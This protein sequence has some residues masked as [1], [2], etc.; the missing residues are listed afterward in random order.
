M[1]HMS[2]L[3]W[4]QND[5]RDAS[6]LCP[7]KLSSGNC[8]GGSPI[9]H[10]LRMWTWMRN[11]EQMTSHGSVSVSLEDWLAENRYTKVLFRGIFRADYLH[12][13]LAQG[14]VASTNRCDFGFGQYYTDSYEVARRFAVAGG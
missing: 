14:P 1:G 3:N 9:P 2:V 10:I 8:V 13:Q 5:H 12:A 7:P 6:A 11:G 4:L